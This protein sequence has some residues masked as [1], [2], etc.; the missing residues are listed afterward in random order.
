MAINKNFVIKN[1]VQVATDLIVG[2]SDTKKVGIGTTI[3]GYTLHVGATNVGGRGGIGATDLNI[4]GV[5][6]VTNFNVT[7]LSTFA[8]DVSVSG[9]VSAQALSIGT[10]EVIDRG[11]RLSGIASLDA[12]TTATIEEAIRVGPNS[13]SDLKVSGISTFVGI[14]TF[15]TGLDVVSGVSTF[16]APLRIG[17]AGTTDHAGVALGATVGFGTSAFFQDG[18]AIYMG[19]DSDLKIFHDS[20]NSFIQDLGTGNL[21]VDSNSLQIRNAT[22]TETQAVFTENGSVELYF[23]NSKKV[24]TTSGGLNVTGITTFSD[25][26]NVVSGVSTFQDNAK[27]TFGA[28]SDLIV[29]HSGSHSFIQDTTGTGNLYIDSNS[30]QIR[31]AA[32]DETQATFAE[33]GA[34][35]LFYDNGNVFQTTPQGVNVSGVTTSNRL[36]ISGVSTFTSIG[37][38]LIP[39]GDGSRNIGAAGS[40]WQDLFIDGTAKI[41]ALEA[42]TAK[43]GDLTNNRVVIVGTSGELEDDGNFT[44]DGTTLAVTGKETV[45]VDITVGSGV[46]IQNHG[47]VS[48]AG[49]TTVG[50]N[51][52][53]GG[54]ILPDEDGSRDLGS[55][56]KEFQDLFIDGTANIDTLAADTAAIGDLTNNRVVIAGSSGELEDDANLTFDGEKFNVGSGVTI[57]PHGGVSIAG[58]V[59][60]GGDLNVK[61][62]ITYDEIT[63]RNLNITGITTFADVVNVNGDVN[64]GNATS[65]TIT[66]TGRFDSN[67]VPSGDTQDL[68]TSSQEW[69]DLFLDGTA[70][71]DTLDVD[72]SATVTTSLTVGTGVTIQSHG[73]VS[74]AGLTTAN[75]GVQV[76]SAITLATNGNLAVTGIVTAKEFVGVFTSAGGAGVGIG[77]TTGLVGYGFTFINFKGPGV[78]TVFAS[79]TTGIATIFFQGGGGGVGAAG[80]WTP[81]GSIGISTSKSVGVNTTAINDPDLQGIGN[82][83]QG[84]YIGNGMLVNDNALNGNHYIGTAFGGMMAGPVTINGVLTVDGNY[85]VV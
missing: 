7:G 58:I 44:F 28:Q 45:S 69:R 41:D 68:G 42:D 22:G 56:S 49:I 57:Q 25:R 4:T 83:F 65:D 80:T 20:S 38:N 47:G 71:V 9:M 2:D 16:G 14:A 48:I 79:S 85:V 11:L 63:G 17:F 36:N 77:S 43:I 61:G 54:D 67:I 50:G 84:L 66:A 75:G 12:V 73:G 37:S 59:T 55:S 8:N 72:E 33:N 13:F 78:S 23:D 74:I 6:T 31:N 35:S 29:Y 53:A 51:L 3:A 34:V 39:D 10:T 32:G 30:L 81:E 60:V 26:I 52:L 21:Y 27:L 76:G 24:E 5:G 15:A 18:A 82:T 19:D 62:D 46:T 40:E 64:L 70:H 1:G